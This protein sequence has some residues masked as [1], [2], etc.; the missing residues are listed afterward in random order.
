MLRFRFQS[1]NGYALAVDC[2]PACSSDQANG[3]TAKM[4][5]ALLDRLPHRCDIIETGNDSHRFKKRK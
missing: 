2:R 5:T 4:T 3:L 1:R